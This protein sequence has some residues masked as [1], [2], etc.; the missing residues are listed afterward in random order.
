MDFVSKDPIGDIWIAV[1]QGDTKKVSSVFTHH[2]VAN[3]TPIDL[4]VYNSEGWSPLHLAVR[5]R[6]GEIVDV[7]LKNGANPNI[8]RRSDKWT[9]LHTACLKEMMPIAS[10]LVRAGADV[11]FLNKTGRS[12][13][14]LCKSD[15]LA[16]TL[17][18]IASVSP[19]VP[20]PSPPSRARAQTAMAQLGNNGSNKNDDFFGALA[21][22]ESSTT[23][24]PGGARSLSQSQDMSML[25]NDLSSSSSGSNNNARSVGFVA[26]NRFKST[27]GSPS[28]RHSAQVPM[29]SNF[30]SQS[31]PN[32]GSRN[33]SPYLESP[34][35]ANFDDA[36]AASWPPR[37]VLRNGAS[38][39]GT[40][41]YLFAFPPKTGSYQYADMGVG[42][43]VTSLATRVYELHITLLLD[44]GV[45]QAN[46][47]FG[48]SHRVVDV[49]FSDSNRSVRVH[50]CPRRG[51]AAIAVA[52]VRVAVRLVQE[53][54]PLARNTRSP[55]ANAN[56]PASNNVCLLGGLMDSP[57]SATLPGGGLPLTSS[58]AS[59]LSGSVMNSLGNPNSNSNNSNSN[60]SNSNSN[61]SSSFANSSISGG[62]PLGDSLSMS[63]FAPSSLSQS[64]APSFQPPSS[65]A[66]SH[67]LI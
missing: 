14:N 67:S 49:A 1:E 42:R 45:V 11:D 38:D 63:G 34:D 35:S 55:S 54:T 31:T 61:L 5:R 20:P 51:S 16:D 60:N 39:G 25:T 56:R 62:S 18:E 9:P 44:S 17:A 36:N 7:L 59:S 3:D 48:T 2:R 64:S 15:T 66:P 33:P 40:E 43:D 26:S 28:R 29:S 37:L 32:Y 46:F 58:L 27:H 47:F 21:M 22:R 53:G 19:T 24:P 12:P 10:S 50:Q 23:P 65:S 13:L 6:H 4:E 30:L 52:E 8:Y 41:L 57:P